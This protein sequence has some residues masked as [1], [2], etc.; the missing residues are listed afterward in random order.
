MKA[1][2][3]DRQVIIEDRLGNYWMPSPVRWPPWKARGT[4]REGRA[5]LAAPSTPKTPRRKT[6]GS[7][8]P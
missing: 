5:G 7:A 8:Q 4:R 1:A 6:I 2:G 3:R